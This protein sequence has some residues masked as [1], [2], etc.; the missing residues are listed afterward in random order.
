MNTFQ[1]FLAEQMKDPEFAAAY[2]ETSAEENVK[3]VTLLLKKLAAQSAVVEAARK[4]RHAHGGLLPDFID[5]VD[6]YEKQLAEKN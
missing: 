2:T 5:T 6:G 1:E 3:L 4:Q